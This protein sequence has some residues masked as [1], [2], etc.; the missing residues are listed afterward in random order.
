MNH[1]NV[2]LYAFY[3]SSHLSI[4]VRMFICLCVL[5]PLL[6]MWSVLLLLFVGEG[7]SPI[8]M[9]QFVYPQNAHFISNLEN[10]SYSHRNTICNLQI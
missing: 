10:Y 2:Y 1:L 3:V 7:N 9:Q 5:I 6:V 8:N 4:C